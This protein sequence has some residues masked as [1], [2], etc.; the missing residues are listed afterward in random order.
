MPMRLVS[1]GFSM[2]TRSVAERKRPNSCLKYCVGELARCVELDR[3]LRRT[4]GSSQGL[5]PGG[6]GLARRP[7]DR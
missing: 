7:L 1:L 4:Q 6:K 5:G 2:N 3:A